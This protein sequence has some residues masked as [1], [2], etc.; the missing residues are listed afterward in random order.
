MYDTAKKQVA[1]YLDANGV[2][3]ESEGEEIHVEKSEDTYHPYAMFMSDSKSIED[4]FTRYSNLL[5]V[6]TGILPRAGGINTTASCMPLI[7]EYI[8]EYYGKR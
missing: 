3:Y 1:D 4:Y 5:I 2:N 6:N 8:G 7:E